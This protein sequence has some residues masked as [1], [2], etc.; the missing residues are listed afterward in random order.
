LFDWPLDE[1]GRKVRRGN[2]DANFRIAIM[3]RDGSNFRELTLD[4]DVHEIGALE[5]R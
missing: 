5:W 4:R 1:Q 3:A 2:D